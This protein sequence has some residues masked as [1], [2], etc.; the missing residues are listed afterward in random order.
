MSIY[1]LF[2]AL[3][4]CL[5][6]DIHV[7][8]SE[9]NYNTRTR[10]LELSISL[11]LDDMDN[12]LTQANG[13]NPKLFTA[14]ED[15]QADDY[16]A[17]YLSKHIKVV[18][19]GQARELIYLGREQ[20]KDLAAVWCHIEVENVASGSIVE[21]TNTAFTEIF[22]DQSQIMEVSKDHRQIDYWLLNKAPFTDSVRL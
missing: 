19:D 6:H 17:D 3:H 21:V 2:L 15:V 13:I 20:S 9:L 8:T 18:V 14:H 16:I 22:D 5:M 7:S 12:A 4:M 1:T 10:S 11:F